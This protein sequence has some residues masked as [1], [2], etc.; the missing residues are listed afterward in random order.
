MTTMKND[1]IY[2]TSIVRLSEIAGTFISKNN[3]SNDSD[4][5]NDLKAVLQE[6]IDTLSNYK[7]ECKRIK[8]LGLFT[9]PENIS[10]VDTQEKLKIFKVFE[11]AYIYYKIIHITVLIRI[12]NLP[13]FIKIKNEKDLHTIKQTKN[14]EII[15]IYNTLVNT[16]VQDDS[17]AKIKLF[18]KKHTKPNS[19][20]EENAPLNDVN[21]EKEVAKG[22]G[23]VLTVE[24]LGTLL[25]NNKSSTLLIDIRPRPEFNKYHISFDNIICVEPI[26]FKESYSDYELERKSL[27]TS[28]NEEIK[29][30]QKRDKFKFI[31]LYTDESYG[32]GFGKQK[33]T[34]LQNM[35]M[36]KSFDKPLENTKI[37]TLQDGIQKWIQAGGKTDTRTA[38]KS[39]KLEAVDDNAIYI[40]GNTSRLNLQAFPKT[41]LNVSQQDANKSIQHMMSNSPTSTGGVYA[42]HDQQHSREEKL[43]KG[44]QRTSSF[45][46]LFTNFRSSSGNSVNSTGSGQTISAPPLSIHDNQS[47]LSYTQ[48]SSYLSYSA[49]RTSQHNGSSSIDYPDASS[50]LSNGM[51]A[52][53]LSNNSNTYSPGRSNNTIGRGNVSPYS[54]PVATFHSRSQ[55]FNESSTLKSGMFSTTASLSKLDHNLIGGQKQASPGHSG[56]SLSKHLPDIPRLPARPSSSSFSST[57]PYKQ[58][59]F[60]TDSSK[61]VL[62]N[63]SVY[64]KGTELDFLTG[65]EN[66][67]N[68]CYLNCIIQCV[69]GTHELT[70]IFLNDSYEKHINLNSKLGSKGVL[71]KNFARLVHTMHDNGTATTGNDR[72]K[73]KKKKIP[74]RPDQFKFACGS[75]NSTFKDM[76]QQDCQEFC[77]FLLD[78]LHEDLNQCGGNPPL[79]ELSKQAEELREKLSF[80]IASS[81]EWERYLT[82]DFS[83]IVDLFQG[84][85]ASRLQ[86]KV[87]NHTSTTY[88]PF[89]VLSVPIPNKK[90]CNILDCFQDFT[91]CE[92]LETDEQWSCPH[93]KKKQPSTKQLTITRLP[94]NLIIHLKRFDN[95]MNK[96]NSFINYPFTLDLTKFWPDDFDG[97]LPPGVTDELPARGQV[98]P[99]NY[100]LYGVACHFGSLQ[101]GHYTA[102]VDK[103]IKNSW[104][105]FDDTAFRPIKNHNEP[106]TSSAYVLFYHRIYNL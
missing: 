57:I 36:N 98:A 101:G 82:T 22:F 42:M 28:P 50:L 76:C 6:C 97:N 68:S 104:Y 91:K 53:S 75:I 71:A 85:Y 58:Q 59:D 95:R 70:K 41:S 34:I 88:Q 83:V 23:D 43:N 7:D 87:C 74:V 2:C 96:N 63:V 51:E 92:N 40:N 56:Y 1:E 67:G 62:K 3:K 106:I 102:Y 90:N 13:S 52:I 47:P 31:V 46:R 103:G 27:I 99:F 10:N 9:H 14:K 73:K 11:S 33:Q 81:I 86:C 72:S 18:I 64:Q 25:A 80:R 65:L 61:D 30:F 45:K 39:Q 66:M 29:L 12:P 79:K 15:E 24:Q 84:Q 54:S 21:I 32:D 49:P 60:M 78:G 44:P 55:S 20:L 38:V 89:S 26:S 37:F 5:S 8:K 48:N 94:R 19:I 105:Y 35:L 77:Q 4:K 16:L 69:L 93:C 100:K 17:I